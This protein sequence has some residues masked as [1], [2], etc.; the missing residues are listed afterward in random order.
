MRCAV[1]GVWKAKWIRVSGE[2]EVQKGK[3]KSVSEQG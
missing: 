2:E 1:R 3:C